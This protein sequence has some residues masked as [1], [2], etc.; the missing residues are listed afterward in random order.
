MNKIYIVESEYFTESIWCVDTIGWVRMNTYFLQD[1]MQILI[2]QD[3]VAVN[4]YSELYHK[5]SW[6]DHMLEWTWE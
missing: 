1:Q 3:D 5:F 4:L 6:Y 2:Q